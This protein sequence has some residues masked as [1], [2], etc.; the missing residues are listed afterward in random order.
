MWACQFVGRSTRF[1]ES[2]LIPALNLVTT[3]WGD[4]IGSTAMQSHCRLAGAIGSSWVVP[5]TL[6]GQIPVNTA[7][8]PGSY[9][10]TV[11]VTVT[12]GGISLCL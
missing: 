9:T 2:E 11:N 5:I 4:S 12:Y 8:V 6:Y 7:A 10:D 1:I 3:V